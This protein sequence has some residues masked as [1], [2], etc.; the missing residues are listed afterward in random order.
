MN[1]Q[2]TLTQRYYE[3]LISD[4]SI[5]AIIPIL[6]RVAKGITS[7]PHSARS[8]QLAI[9]LREESDSLRSY[10]DNAIEITF[11]PKD[12]EIKEDLFMDYASYCMR[13]DLKAYGKKELYKALEDAGLKEVRRGESRRYGYFG[14][15]KKV[16]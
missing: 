11:D 10:L 14:I 1:H 7:I 9:A 16:E 4:S 15:K 3:D 13:N 12:F 2:L 8:K 6:G 5:L